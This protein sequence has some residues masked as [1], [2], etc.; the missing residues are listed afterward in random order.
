MR[1][2]AQTDLIDGEHL[3]CRQIG[4]ISSDGQSCRL[5]AVL[6]CFVLTKVLSTVNARSRNSAVGKHAHLVPVPVND[7]ANDVNLVLR[8][9]VQ[10]ILRVGREIDESMR[11]WGYGGR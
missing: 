2:E 4:Q 9:R 8:Q 5:D 11:L 6:L 1:S 10:L 7:T 3:P